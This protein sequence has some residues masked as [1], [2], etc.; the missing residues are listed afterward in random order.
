MSIH[1][2]LASRIAEQIT[3]VARQQ[4]ARERAERRRLARGARHTVSYFHQA[5]DPYSC[6]LAQ[7]LPELA[8]RYDVDLNCHLVSAPPDWAAPEREKLDEWAC[9][10]ARRLAHRAGLWSDSIAVQP[11]PEAVAKAEATLAHSLNSGSFIK[12]AARI[13]EALWSDKVLSLPEGD[14]AGAKAEGDAL[15]ARLGHYL[16]GMLHYAGEWYW[17][18]DRLHY[19]EERLADVGAR[20]ATA[21]GGPIYAQPHSP[22]ADASHM[23]SAQGEDLHFYLSFRSPYTWIAAARAKALTDAYGLNLKLRFVLPM[24]MRGLPVPPAKRNYIT[25]DAA[26]E[27]RRVGVPFGR[28]ADPVGKPVERGYSLLPWAIEQGRGYAFCHAFMSAV[29]SQGIDAGSDGGLRKIVE[30][31]GLDWCQARSRMGN[32]EWRAEA[33]ANRQELFDLGLWGVPCFRFRDTAAW[34][35]DRLWAVEHAI[36]NT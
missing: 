12:D 29:W 5:G 33:E 23:S 11:G 19:L 28:V 4:K 10:D 15:R 31:S 30:A 7:V 25:L 13:S 22:L 2:F 32:V 14:A 8:A 6:L 1:T 16:G 35:Q 9:R 18:L 21:S 20:K 17:G 27:A 34:G 26:R 24:V 36:R 3:G